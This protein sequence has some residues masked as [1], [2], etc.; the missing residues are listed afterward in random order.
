MKSA[1]EAN[2]KDIINAESSLPF[3]YIIEMLYS[4]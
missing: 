2:N 4:F 3:S 1:N